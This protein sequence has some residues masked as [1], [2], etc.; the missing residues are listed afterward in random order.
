LIVVVFFYWAALYLYTPTLPTYVQTKTANLALVGVVLSMYGLWQAVIRLPLGIAADWTGRRKPF[1]LLGLALAGLGALLMGT[2]PDVQGIL[3]GRAITGLAA[4]TW[5]P[6]VVVFSGLFSPAEAVQATSLLTLVGSLGRVLATSVTGYLNDL[7]GYPLAFLLATG[8]AGLAAALMLAFPE[9]RRPYR[10]PSPTA[11]G[12]LITRRDVLMPSLLGA[13]V[14]F[15]HWGS[16][17]SFLPILAKQLGASDVALSALVSLNI[18]L[19]TVGNL[20][21]TAL[22]SR[23]GSRRIVY[24]SFL[25]LAIG[26][27]GAALAPALFWLFILQGL[28]GLAVGV[29][30][31][32]LMGMSIE[33]VVDA[34]RTTAMG[35]HQSVYAIGMFGGPWLSGVM[36]EAFG[37]RLMFTIIGLAA[38]LL[39]WLGTRFLVQPGNPTRDS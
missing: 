23:L 12:I 15:A 21:A 20:V 18:V 27:A 39:G 31:P 14:Q 29:C 22:V 30:Y 32:V 10:R 28:I 25:T 11:I 33:Q 13:V 4:G 9:A 26:V 6:L 17:F 24:L 7:G 38:L 37:L 36:A 16:T 19:Y 3:I 5:V 8:L 35:L 2:A 1:I 34:E